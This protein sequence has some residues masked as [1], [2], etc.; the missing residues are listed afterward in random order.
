MTQADADKLNRIK[1]T[2]LYFGYLTRTPTPERY[3]SKEDE[4]LK[5]KVRKASYNGYVRTNTKLH[6][7]H[8]KMQFEPQL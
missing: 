1:G 2:V 4:A 7:R 8:T 6:G 3:N 5:A